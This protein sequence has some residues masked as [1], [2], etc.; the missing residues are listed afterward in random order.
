MAKKQKSKKLVSKSKAEQALDQLNRDFWP[1]TAEWLITIGPGIEVPEVRPTTEGTTIKLRMP[2]DKV[3]G[4]H[5]GTRER[6]HK[7]N[8]KISKKKS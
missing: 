1:C 4:I 2:Q 3:G 8:F 5:L 7:V 6:G